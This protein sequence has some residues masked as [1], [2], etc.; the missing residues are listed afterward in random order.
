MLVLLQGFVLHETTR[1]DTRQHINVK[2]INVNVIRSSLSECV[3]FLS[4]FSRHEIYR[5]SL[6]VVIA[7]V[8]ITAVLVLVL[9]SITT[10]VIAAVLVD[11]ARGLHCD[12]A[13]LAIFGDP[14]NNI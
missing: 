9:V 14:E 11:E 13:S 2:H 10:V 12:Q 5:Q 4:Y 8:A 6:T 1:Y 3:H 7:A